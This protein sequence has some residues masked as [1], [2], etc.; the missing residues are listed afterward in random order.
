MS[1]TCLAR[2]QAVADGP[3]PPPPGPPPSCPAC[4]PGLGGAPHHKTDLHRFVKWPKYV[5]IQRQKRVL[6]MRLK[7]PP[8]LNQFVTRALEKN[9]AETL[10][11]LLLKYRW[12]GGGAEICPSSTGG[13]GGRGHEGTGVCGVC[14][15]AGHEGTGGWVGRGH[16]GTGEGAEGMRAQV[17]VGGRGHIRSEWQ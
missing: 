4:V 16:E 17:G 14:V 2:G 13:W 5:R 8:V 15:C 1:P 3:P 11:K 6:S 7:V 9:Q 12:V 10:F